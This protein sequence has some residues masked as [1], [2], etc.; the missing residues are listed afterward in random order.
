MNCDFVNSIHHAIAM[1]HS[2]DIMARTLIEL[3]QTTAT[4]TSTT[5]TD[6]I[7][8]TAVTW[9]QNNYSLHLT[10]AAHTHSINSAI[11]HQCTSHN[12]TDTKHHHT[13]NSPLPLPSQSTTIKNGVNGSRINPLK[14][15]INRPRNPLHT[16]P[17]PIPPLHRTTKVQPRI[18][19]IQTSRR[20]DIF[21]SD[22]PSPTL[23][24]DKL[25]SRL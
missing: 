9:S 8:D 15:I 14:R 20:T 21:P 1:R 10:S 19:H 18:I 11:N 17:D 2:C 4:A 23:L 13:P 16:R 12:N 22:T 5:F 3:P 7:F 24:E 25:R 6:L